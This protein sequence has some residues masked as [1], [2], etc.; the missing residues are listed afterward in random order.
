MISKNDLQRLSEFVW[1]VPR[2]YRADMRAPARIWADEELLDDALQDKSVEQ[3]INTATMPGIVKYAI[4]MPDIH[5]GYGAPV[6]GV[7]ATATR[8][9]VI[10]PGAVGYDINCLSGDTRIL[11]RFGYT[12][13]IAEMEQSWHGKQIVCHDLQEGTSTSTEILRYLKLKPQRPVFRLVTGSGDEVIATSDH[14]FWTPD[15]MIPLGELSAGAKIAMHPF[16]GVPYAEPDSEILVSEKDIKKRLRELGKG[17][18]GNA[19]VQILNHLKQ[20]GL[21]PLRA[22]SPAL[23]HLIKLLGLCL[24]DGNIYFENKE[25]AGI[26]WFFGEADDL[27]CVRQDIA[28]CGFSPSTVYARERDNHIETAYK[29]YEFTNTTYSI[30]VASSAFALLLNVLGAPIGKKTTQD[31]E[32]PSWL[33]RAPLWHKRLFLASFFG[34]ELSAPKSF[35]ERNYNFYPPVLSLT[36]YQGFVASGKRFLNGIAKLLDEFGVQATKLS[37]HVE[38]ANA[39]GIAAHRLRLLLS[40]KSTSLLALWSRVGFEFNAENQQKAMAA[41]QYLKR[42]EKVTAQRAQTRTRAREMQQAGLPRSNIFAALLSPSVNVRFLERSLYENVRT[43]PRVNSN[44][45]K[46]DTFVSQ[47][48]ANLEHSNMVWETIAHIE[49]LEWDAY[50]YDF[51]VGHPDHNFVANG[52]VVSNCGVRVLASHVS[53]EEIQPYLGNLA[54]TLYRNCPSGVGVSGSINLYGDDLDDILN[55]G[56]EWTLE[57]GYARMEDLPH[58]EEYGRIPYADATQVSHKAKERGRDQLGTLGAGN[59]FI[60]VDRITAIYD[61]EAA[62]VLGLFENQAVVQIHCGSR[63]L[64]HQV[65]Q[66]YVD[67]FQRVVKEYDIVLPDRELVAAPF[68]SPEGHAYVGGMG[69]AANFAFANRQVLAFHI[70]RSFAEV[71]KGHVKDFDLHQVYDIAHNMAKVEEHDVDGVMTQV[72]VHRKG[73]TR[74]FGPNSPVLPDN[75]KAIGQPVLI[76]GSMG[77][78]SFILCGTQGSMAQTFGSSCHG[79]GRVWSRHRAKK[80][81]RGE[82]LRAEMQERGIEVRAGSLSG[83]AEEAPQ[84]YKDVSRVVQVVDAAGIGKMVARLE[85]MAVIKG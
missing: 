69:A 23:P 33:F 58:T 30:K 25:G 53:A 5:Q 77:T 27:E 19:D 10:S 85:P 8:D 7:F 31:F 79:A 43:S 64:G 57:R 1:Q 22:D 21:L 42:K 38:R 6:G 11:H 68:T 49:P 59:H 14:P 12:Q 71:L 37:E 13:T 35:D 80:E 63:G 70:R 76:P 75:L 60:E 20:R 83:L 29:T 78:M 81:I 28:A 46:F 84:A 50:V 74:A 54:T 18:A 32:I 2:E 47:A 9:G 44:F 15:G 16:E 61:A 41:V 66:D 51:T 17:R 36:K 52:F 40:S 24:G 55:R 39:D 67:K 56:A 3:L 34:A 4:A 48:T 82:K 26:T 62:R 73:A 45:T 65:C 72:L